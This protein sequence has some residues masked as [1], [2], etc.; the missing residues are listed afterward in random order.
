M[1]RKLRAALFG[2][3]KPTAVR[4]GLRRKV[5]GS[6]MLI[7][8]ESRRLN[9]DIIQFQNKLKE[10]QTLA[11]NNGKKVSEELVR[12]FFQEDGLEEEKLKKVFD[13]LEIQG[14]Q[15]E[16]SGSEKRRTAGQLSGDFSSGER[17]RGTRKT[18][19]QVSDRA[20][21]TGYE[22]EDKEGQKERQQNRVP[23]SPEEEEYLKE[24]MEAFQDG[25]ED[26]DVLLKLFLQGQEALESA[27]VKS[28]QREILEAA[29][30]YNREEIFF[31]DLLQEGNMGFLTALEA[32]EALEARELD[33]W[34]QTQIR[35]AMETFIEA[36]SQ[37]KKEDDILVERVR[38]LEA[39]VKEL[40]ED[41]DVKYSVEELAA[42]LDMDIEEMEGVLRLAGEAPEN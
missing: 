39:R 1:Y 4:I 13:Y 17:D 20:S 5:M 7:T 18:S 30:D 16:G 19:D 36:Q 32:A 15:V 6:A 10:I 42:F 23:L 25:E 31:G 21:F 24:Y 12:R 26:R 28:Y 37:Q 27:L 33:K 35:E 29:R 38:N 34:L 22:G 2:L 3:A 40:T 41:E 8:E 14:I 11:L 9:M